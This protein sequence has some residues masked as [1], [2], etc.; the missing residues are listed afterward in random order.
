MDELKMMKL[1]MGE[2]ISLLRQ[3]AGKS[4]EEVAAHMKMNVASYMRLEDDFVYPKDEQLT[5]LGQLYGL[6]YEE[7]IRV[8]ED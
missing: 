7:V 6:T 8:G 4:V 3:K 5:K 1:T 2:K